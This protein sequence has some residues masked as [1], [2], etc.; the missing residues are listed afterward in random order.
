MLK[1][2]AMFAVFAV[3]GAGAFVLTISAQP[4]PD[5]DVSLSI[6]S[7]EKPAKTAQQQT[8][9]WIGV[10]VV[11]VPDVLLPH[12]ASKDAMHGLA[13]IDHVVPNGPAAKFGL[14]RGDVI[15]QFGGKDIHSFADLVEQVHAAKD[16]EQTVTVIRDGKKAEMKITPAQRPNEQVI[17]PRGGIAP[18]GFRRMPQVPPQAG[19]KFGRD[20]WVGPRDPQQ[21]MREMEEY[22]RQMQGGTDDDGGLILDG[23]AETDNAVQ[24]GSQLAVSSF[25]ENGKTK[26][27]VKQ[28]IQNGGKTEEK[29]WEAEKTE[30]L[31]QEI[32]GEVRKMLGE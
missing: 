12:F 20:V 26:I 29:N 8:A 22:F 24:S 19:M 32:R 2:L 3:L 16:G 13:V 11:P 27:K 17:Q 6:T 15:L 21:M 18:F 14:Q 30:D 23:E 28:V 7:E 5:K 4:Q 25:T 10:S 9:Y 1:K 31:P